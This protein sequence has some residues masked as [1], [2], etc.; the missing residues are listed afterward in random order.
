MRISHSHKLIYLAVPRTGSTTARNIL[1]V[2]AD[3]TSIHISTIT[4]DFPFYHHISALELKKIFAARGW[5]WDGYRKFCVIRNPYD[6]VVSLYHHRVENLAKNAHQSPPSFKQ[7][8]FQLNPTQRLPTSLQAFVCDESGDFLVQDILQFEQL[9]TQLPAYLH[10]IGISLSADQIPRL[11]A[12]RN[13]RSYRDYY[14][15]ETKARIGQL[16]RYEIERFGYVF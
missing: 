15:A 4:P 1:D 2:S 14:D 7:Y 9:H 8:V 12:S 5:N 6:R 11:N 3:I 10:Q 13:R 16:Y